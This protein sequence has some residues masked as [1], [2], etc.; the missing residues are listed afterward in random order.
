MLLKAPDTPV[1]SSIPSNPSAVTP[2][3]GS[4]ASGLLPAASITSS[5]KSAS[6]ATTGIPLAELLELLEIPK[7]LT[8]RDNVSLSFAWS[9]YKAHNA[10]EHLLQKIA[11]EGR[12]PSAYPHLTQT[13]LIEVF[14]SK[15]TWHTYYRPVFS[16]VSSH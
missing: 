3:S 2:I 15:T 7:S 16:K 13:Q 1:H 10:A 14:T 12:W 8:Q 9:K 5:S 4:Q 11:A 6:K